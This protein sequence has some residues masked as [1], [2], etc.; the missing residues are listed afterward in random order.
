MA[1]FAD[2]AYFLRRGCLPATPSFLL[3]V[4]LSFR[5]MHHIALTTEMRATGQRDGFNIRPQS[6]FARMLEALGDH[7]RLY[8]GFLAR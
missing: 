3:S 4:Y 2:K 1:L 5:H 8:M 6:Y 7:V